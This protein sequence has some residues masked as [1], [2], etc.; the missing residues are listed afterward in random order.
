MRNRQ[1]R[2]FVTV[3]SLTATLAACGGVAKGR[4]EQTSPTTPKQTITVPATAPSTSVTTSSQSSAVALQPVDGLVATARADLAVY[5]STDSSTPASTLP[6]HTSF[7]SPTTLLV[8][9]WQGRTGAWLQ[10]SLPTRPNGSHGFVHM[11]DVTL[12]SVQRRVDVDL[13]AKVLRVFGAAG[14]VELQSTVA[15]GSPQNPTP[16]GAFFVTD[17]IDTNNA[18]S[19]YGPKAV[20]VSGHSESLSE[21]NGGDGAIGIHGTNNPSSIGKAVSHGCVRVPNSVVVQLAA[22]LALGTPVTIH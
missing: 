8:Q 20:G 17:V 2:Q 6:S 4:A 19:D 13:A 21:F 14:N 7:G 9:Q 16:T 12:A 10:V 1:I 11:S 15:I 18:D 5:T 3:M 22:M